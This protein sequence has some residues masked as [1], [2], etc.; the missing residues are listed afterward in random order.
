MLVD[1]KTTNTIIVIFVEKRVHK[2][3]KIV[4]RRGSDVNT[5]ISSVG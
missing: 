4:G 3:E 2:I 5:I 1:E